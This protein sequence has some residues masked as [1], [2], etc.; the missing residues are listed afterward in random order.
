MSYYKS[1]ILTFPILHA[2]NDGI[3]RT[4]ESSEQS[5]TFWG[6]LR[7]FKENFFPFHIYFN[8]I[9][10]SPSAHSRCCQISYFTAC[11]VGGYGSGNDKYST[12][13]CEVCHVSL[14][15]YEVCVNIHR[16]YLS[17]MWME[18]KNEI[19]LVKYSSTLKCGTLLHCSR[20]LLI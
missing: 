10:N 17:N 15:L 5:V 9:G 14:V 7:Y 8:G 1:I 13:A 11:I 12:N 2:Q 4:A 18:L 6:V 3:Y 16:K 19:L 20:A